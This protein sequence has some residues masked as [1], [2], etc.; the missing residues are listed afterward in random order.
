MNSGCCSAAERPFPA[1]H[2]TTDDRGRFRVFNYIEDSVQTLTGK[3]LYT[4][5]N[6]G[7][8]MENGAFVKGG[9]LT[10]K[11]NPYTP[12]RSKRNRRNRPLPKDTK[13]LLKYE[14]DLFWTQRSHAYGHN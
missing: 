8:A 5:S 2:I 7:N 14:V 9:L 13:P 3:K 11:T 1:K 10:M 12:T 6:I 4:E